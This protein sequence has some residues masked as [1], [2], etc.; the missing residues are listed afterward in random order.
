MESR[1]SHPPLEN[2]TRPLLLFI[3]EVRIF[4]EIIF[5]EACVTYLLCFSRQPPRSSWIT[6]SFPCLGV[7]LHSDQPQRQRYVVPLPPSSLT[8]PHCLR[9][10]VG[11]NIGDKG[12]KSL[13]TFLE[14]NSSLS[15]LNI[16]GNDL[17]DAGVTPI[18]NALKTNGHLK[19]INLGG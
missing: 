16:Y 5:F 9:F 1:K 19:S 2:T 17:K 14:K 18:A 6:T 4:L 13:A 15:N 7:Q 11:N 12:A 8:S 10:F 3:L